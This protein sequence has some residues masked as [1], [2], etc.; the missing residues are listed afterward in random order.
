MLSKPRCYIPI[1]NEY[2]LNGANLS[3]LDIGL[4]VTKLKAELQ[5]S[6]RDFRS[7]CRVKAQSIVP[8]TEKEDQIVSG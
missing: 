7:E 5:L 8:V 1:H 3:R 6:L 4:F 2:P